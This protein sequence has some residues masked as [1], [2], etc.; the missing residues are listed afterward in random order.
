M[1]TNPHIPPRLARL[2]AGTT[3]APEQVVAYLQPD[4]RPNDYR[5]RRILRELSPLMGEG[6]QVARDWVVAQDQPV[7]L[8]W[9]T[10]VW[11][12]GSWHY[13]IVCDALDLEIR[14]EYRSEIK[15]RYNENDESPPYIRRCLD[16]EAALRAYKLGMR[17]QS[18]LLPNL[19]W[20]ILEALTWKDTGESGVY[21]MARSRLQDARHATRAL[22][23]L[24][25]WI[26]STPF[27]GA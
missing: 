27:G 1:I 15:L 20:A 16:A 5:K 9:K 21:L 18:G 19:N 24:D 3:A 10:S 6:V 8:D 4:P 11:G 26:A 13:N 22:I 2:L 25:T 7:T 17:Y 12:P 23:A 14:E